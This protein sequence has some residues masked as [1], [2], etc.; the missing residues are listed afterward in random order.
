M[1]SFCTNTSKYGCNSE[2]LGFWSYHSMQKFLATNSVDKASENGET[3]NTHTCRTSWDLLVHFVKHRN[4]HVAKCVDDSTTHTPKKSQANKNLTTIST[5]LQSLTF[6]PG[7]QEPTP[8]FQLHFQGT[9]RNSKVRPP[10]RRSCVAS[11]LQSFGNK[12]VTTVVLSFATCFFPITFGGIYFGNTL[13]PRGRDMTLTAGSDED[14]LQ[15]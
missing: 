4:E 9:K 3:Q 14:H 13:P 8:T 1:I 15:L 6:L 11:K 7:F 2:T 12:R 5:T 10:G